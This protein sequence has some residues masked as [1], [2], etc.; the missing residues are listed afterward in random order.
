[1]ILKTVTLGCCIEVNDL[2]GRKAHTVG[3]GT[4]GT[5]VLMR[6]S[7]TPDFTVNYY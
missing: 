6:A 1:M 3:S 7:M 4:I 5:E 2:K